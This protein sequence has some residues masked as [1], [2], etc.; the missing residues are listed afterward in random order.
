MHKANLIPT[1][2]KMYKDIS[3]LATKFRRRLEIADYHCSNLIFLSNS[4]VCRSVIR[5]QGSGWKEGKSLYGLIRLN[6]SEDEAI[7]LPSYEGS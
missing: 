4:S 6:S 5:R 7:F 1:S 2:Q 3:I